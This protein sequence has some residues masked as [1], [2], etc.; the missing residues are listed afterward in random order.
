V[1]ENKGGDEPTSARDRR[2]GRNEALLRSV[3]ERIDE[4][5]GAFALHDEPLDFICECGDAACSERVRLPR[6]DY[7]RVRRQPTWFVVVAGHEKPEV[8]RVVGR[9]GEYLIVDKVDPDAAAVARE[10]A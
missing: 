6:S 4:V 5:G 8:E 2:I 9:I 10:S 3:N 7:D 1:T